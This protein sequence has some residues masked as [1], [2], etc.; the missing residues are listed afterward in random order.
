MAALE[1]HLG[2][3]LRVMIALSATTL[4]CTLRHVFQLWNLRCGRRLIVSLRHTSDYVEYESKEVTWQTDNHFHQFTII[5]HDRIE[6]HPFKE[7]QSQAI[8]M[9]KWVCRLEAKSK[10]YVAPSSSFS[11][12]IAGSY[13]SSCRASSFKAESSASLLPKDVS[14]SLIAFA[15]DSLLLSRSLR[16]D[17][18]ACSVGTDAGLFDDTR[19]ASRTRLSAK[20]Q[21]RQC[22][23][24]GSKRKIHTLEFQMGFIYVFFTPCCWTSH[25]FLSR[26]DCKI[27]LIR[28]HY[29]QHFADQFA[30][31]S[32]GSICIWR[33]LVDQKK[34]TWLL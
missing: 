30:V 19:A 20:S 27:V 21:F 29:G 25:C 17:I 4:L 33:T 3:T 2:G 9:K 26:D 10:A 32:K 22:I 14:A 34:L 23:E 24:I 18:C 7:C 12:S 15:R 16:V 6:S 11:W 8:R 1:L 13:P 28:I 5:V 31:S